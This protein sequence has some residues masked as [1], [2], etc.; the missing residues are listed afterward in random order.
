MTSWSEERAR[1]L[2][3]PHVSTGES[4]G[5]DE[6]VETPC[7]CSGSEMCPHHFKEALEDWLDRRGGAV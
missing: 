3:L 7:G 6:D 4:G 1:L 2:A 5:S